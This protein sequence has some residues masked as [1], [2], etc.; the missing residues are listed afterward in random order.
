[1][2][3]FTH[4]DLVLRAEKWLKSQGC[5]VVFRDPFRAVIASNNLIYEE[6]LTGK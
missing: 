3:V 5:G 2:K 1:M 4:S 6:V